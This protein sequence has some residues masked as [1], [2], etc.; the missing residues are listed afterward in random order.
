[1][2]LIDAYKGHIDLSTL[3]AMLDRVNF[4]NCYTDEPLSYGI[5][6]GS[7]S[8]QKEW[9]QLFA[10]HGQEIEI[11]YL[12]RVAVISDKSF[13]GTLKFF[14]TRDLIR[15]CNY[16][17]LIV[18]GTILRIEV[19]HREH[20]QTTQPTT[21][22]EGN[23]TTATYNSANERASI[24]VLPAFPLV[25]RDSGPVPVN[26]D[27]HGLSPRLEIPKPLFYQRPIVPH[28]KDGTYLIYRFYDPK[29]LYIHNL[30]NAGDLA[31]GQVPLFAK[32][33]RGAAQLF[34]FNEGA[35]IKNIAFYT[36]VTCPKKW[37]I[38]VAFSRGKTILFN[39]SNLNINETAQ[40]MFVRHEAYHSVDEALG[41]AREDT[42]KFVAIWKGINSLQT[43]EL[44]KFVYSIIELMGISQIK[45]DTP[46]GS[47][48]VEFFPALIESLNHPNLA[49]K[50]STASPKIRQYFLA[51]IIA[52][53]ESLRGKIADHAQIFGLI[54]RAKHM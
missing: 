2:G 46:T 8:C 22:S 11:T 26:I 16:P 47:D 12:P 24:S 34:G 51:M 29:T 28:S 4:D 9:E 10:L 14:V 23:L 53:E 21:D 18:D 13:S 17:S 52:L 7:N 15:N 31:E 42:S 32:G 1:M 37:S 35:I 40:A 33:T 3:V 41:I 30:V 25:E 50:L 45:M 48:P 36:A 39:I 19:T 6:R 43:I 20:Q 5:T 38:G 44:C 27:W 49:T 54:D